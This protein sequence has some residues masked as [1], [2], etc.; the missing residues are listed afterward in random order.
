V[1]DTLGELGLWYRLSRVAMVGGSW[2]PIGGHN[3]FEAST[4]NTTVVHGP[5]V[6]NFSE[7]YADLDAQGLSVLAHTA[8]QIAAT[9]AEVWAAVPTHPGE[10]AVVDERNAA[11]IAQLLTHLAR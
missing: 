7:S 10:P 8:E 6:A 1:A 9:V 4:L 5:E 11:Q 3:P 2:A